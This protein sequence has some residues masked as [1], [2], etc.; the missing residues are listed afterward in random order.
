M[1][2]KITVL[3]LIAILTSACSVYRITS[4]ETSPKYHPPRIATSVTYLEKVRQSHEIIGSVTVKTERRQHM[5]EII[6]KMKRE[7]GTIGGNA[8]TDIQTDATGTW[9]KIP[10]QKLLGNAYIRANFSAK[11]VVF[12]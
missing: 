1:I 12:K 7:A 11:V 8:I 3:L 4:E 9:K 10:P 2:K 6:E 5:E